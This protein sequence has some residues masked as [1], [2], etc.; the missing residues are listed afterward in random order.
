VNPE[1]NKIILFEG[2]QLSFNP[3]QVRC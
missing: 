1:K 3:F 2:R